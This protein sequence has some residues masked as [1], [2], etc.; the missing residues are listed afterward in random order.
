MD[1]GATAGGLNVLPEEYPDVKRSDFTE[2]IHG[3][4]IPDPYRWLED[5]NSEET[6]ECVLP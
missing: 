3:S 1:A 5:P 4:S 6:K 2:T